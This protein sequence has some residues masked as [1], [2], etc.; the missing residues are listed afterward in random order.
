MHVYLHTKE[1]HIS[2]TKLCLVSS[3]GV[4]SERWTDS[5]LIQH[6]NYNKINKINLNYA[7]ST[8]PSNFIS[9]FFFDTRLCMF[10]FVFVELIQIKLIFLELIW[11][12]L[13]L[14]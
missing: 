13:I 14:R 12:E 11:L 4:V 10:D 6:L 1:V 3:P 8:T 9:I 5:L 2:Q 7:S